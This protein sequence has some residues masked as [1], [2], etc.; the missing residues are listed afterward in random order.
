MFSDNKLNQGTQKKIIL[1]NEKLKYFFKY[2]FVF[3]M[4]ENETGLEP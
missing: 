3:H 4:K 2:T 1:E